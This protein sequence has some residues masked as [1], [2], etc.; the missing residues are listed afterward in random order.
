M[1]DE[2]R[3]ADG[4]QF[5]YSAGEQKGIQ[6]EVERIRNQYMEENSDREIDEKLKRLRMLD[7]KAKTPALIVALALGVVGTL[8][9]GTGMSLCLA[10]GH[11]VAGIIVGVLGMGILS[12]AYPVHQIMLKKG[13]K[14][15]GEEIRNLSSELLGEK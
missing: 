2:H 6:D 10:L 15:Y 8:I 11:M 13:K 3:M 7:Q 1:K 12:A 5:R 4:Y 14:K 9:L